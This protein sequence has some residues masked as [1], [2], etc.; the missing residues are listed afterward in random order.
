MNTSRD[1]LSY[2]TAYSNSTFDCEIQ[3][4]CANLRLFMHVTLVTGMADAGKETLLV[5]QALRL[6]TL[7]KLTFADGKLFDALVQDVFPGI[8]HSDVEYANL[9]QAVKDVCAE[10]KLMVI[11]R[12]VLV[13]HIPPA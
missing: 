3:V 10:T 6:N 13:Q 5:V 11:D 12:Q 7:S 1:V 4:L 9:T 2:K 8:S